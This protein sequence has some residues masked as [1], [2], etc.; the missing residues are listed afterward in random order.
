MSHYLTPDKDSEGV[1]RSRG[2]LRAFALR[3]SKKR[4]ILEKRGRLDKQRVTR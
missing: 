1:T 4:E 2:E 3:K